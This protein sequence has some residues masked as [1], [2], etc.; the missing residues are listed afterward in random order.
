MQ[1]KM[2]HAVD[3]IEGDCSPSLVSELAVGLY[4]ALN[5]SSSVKKCYGLTLTT[6]S[7]AGG[8]EA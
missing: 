2:A 3:S 4:M 8:M 5:L 1:V 6:A 7:E